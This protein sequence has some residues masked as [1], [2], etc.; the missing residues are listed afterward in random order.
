MCCAQH[1]EKTHISASAEDIEVHELLRHYY[2]IS[3][4]RR[5][6]QLKSAIKVF[7]SIGVPCY[8]MRTSL[9]KIPLDTGKLEE[10]SFIIHVAL[11]DLLESLIMLSFRE[12][13]KECCFKSIWYTVKDLSR[14]AYA[15]N[16]VKTSILGATESAMASLMFF[17]FGIDSR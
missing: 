8:H 14:A 6:Y 5:K 4:G 9:E 1:A 16:S 13:R 3:S 12:V 11:G 10:M 15:M 17:G 2:D 7:C